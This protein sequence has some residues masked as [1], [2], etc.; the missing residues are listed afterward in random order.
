MHFLTASRYNIVT[1]VRS[2]AK[3]EAILAAHPGTTQA[4]LSFDIVEDIA[5][6]GAFDE[7]SATSES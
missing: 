2:R 3:G 1:T 4:E 7:V 6:D 5:Q